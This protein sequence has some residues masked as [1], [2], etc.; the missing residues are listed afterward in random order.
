MTMENTKQL[1]ADYD[2]DTA[3]MLFIIIMH[4]T[5][6]KGFTSIILFSHVFNPVN[7]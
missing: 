3:D 4:L 1:R 6:T 5:A 7:N 2:A